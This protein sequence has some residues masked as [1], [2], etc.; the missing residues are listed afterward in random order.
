[1]TAEECY[2]RNANLTRDSTL[3][4]S[5]GLDTIAAS[6]A[7][8]GVLF[9]V[10]PSREPVDVELLICITARVAPEDE[11]LFVCAASWI[12]EHHAFVNGAR[13]SAFAAPRPCQLGR[14]RGAAVSCR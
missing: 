10:Q 11:R 9:G 2:G 7:R 12:A 1:V 5:L 14:S 4:D 13:L 3:S 8:L 6:W